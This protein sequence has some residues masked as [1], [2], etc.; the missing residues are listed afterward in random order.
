MKKLKNCQGV[1]LII[2]IIIVAII[3][4][5]I[6]IFKNMN[7]SNSD[8]SGSNSSTSINSNKLNTIVTAD[9]YNTIGNM[10]NENQDE[11]YY[12][13]YA[14]LYYSF[15]ERLTTGIDEA[16]AMQK[17]YGKT[18]QQLVDEGKQL[19]K[20]NNIT[21]EQYKKQLKESN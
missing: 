4:C 2:L 9:N 7:S 3:L 6:L 10:F 8:N 17:I 21:V 1:S 19:M 20:D 13:T 12:F 14:C 11:L 5:V 15:T 18:V 16:T